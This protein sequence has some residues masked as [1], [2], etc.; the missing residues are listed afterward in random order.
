VSA[1]NAGVAIAK[2]WNGCSLS[3][4]HSQPVTASWSCGFHS[5][6]LARALACDRQQNHFVHPDAGKRQ[7]T[8]IVGSEA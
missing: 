3:I 6:K 2:H 8:S 7:H 1:C 5:T 4:K